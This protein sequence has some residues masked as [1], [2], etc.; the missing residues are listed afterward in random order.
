MPDDY[1]RVDARPDA[2][3]AAIGQGLGALSAGTE[4]AT[5]FYGQV[6]ADDGTNSL[7]D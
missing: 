2:F 5:Q 7:C 6:A 1:Q 4:K 3:G